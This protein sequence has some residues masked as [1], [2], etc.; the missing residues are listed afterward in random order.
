MAETVTSYMVNVAG[1]TLKK[2]FGDSAEAKAFA[3]RCAKAS[4]IDV[5]IERTVDGKLDSKVLVIQ[6]NG[7]ARFEYVRR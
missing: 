1:G 6:P 4:T 2:V 3:L 7:E 5:F